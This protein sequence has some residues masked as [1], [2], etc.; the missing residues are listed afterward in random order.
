VNRSREATVLLACVAV[1]LLLLA[2]LTVNLTR[3]GTA[4][5]REV[6]HAQVA[7]VQTMGSGAP[8]RNNALLLGHCLRRE[9]LKSARAGFV[10]PDTW[11]LSARLR[12]MP[13]CTRLLPPIPPA[14]PPVITAPRIRPI[15]TSAP[16]AARPLVRAG[17]GVQ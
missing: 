12:A 4:I 16:R 14:E 6:G 7:Y 10:H 17:T 9:M 5:A 2:A 3:L 8:V 1:A 13:V 11:A 15:V